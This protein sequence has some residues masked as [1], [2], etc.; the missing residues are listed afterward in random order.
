MGSP[1]PVADGCRRPAAQR[2][3]FILLPCM[4]EAL[5]SGG[6]GLS[7]AFDLPSHRGYDSDNPRAI[8]DVGLAG[9]QP[10]VCA[11]IFLYAS[12]L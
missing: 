5:R 12:L 11:N 2:A 10:P 8:G 9:V 6:R 1:L 4:Q 3:L 7:V